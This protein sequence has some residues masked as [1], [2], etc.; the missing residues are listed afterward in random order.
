MKRQIFIHLGDATLSGDM[1]EDV[2]WVVKEPDNALSPLFHGDLKTASN[3]AYGCRVVVF[4]S[5]VEVLLTQVELPN[6]NRQKLLKAIPFALEEQLA[7]DVD[8]LHFAVGERDKVDQISC[9]IVERNIIEKWLQG[10]NDA[11]I[12]P[13]VVSTEVFGVPYEENVW[14]L[15]VKRASKESGA[16]AILRNNPQA[17]MALDVANVVPLLRASLESLAEE[18]RPKKLHVVLCDESR[19]IDPA[20][21]EDVTVKASSIAVVDEAVGEDARGSS[22]APQ[23]NRK[24]ISDIEREHDELTTAISQLESLCPPMG[25]DVAIDHNDQSYLIYIAQQFND[26]QCLNLLQGDYSR[27]ERLEKLFRPWRPA[28]AIGL[29][30]IVL[31]AGLVFADYQQLSK[32]DQML[33]T[34]IEQIYRDAFPDSKNIVDPK[35]QMERGLAQLRE[36]TNQSTD[37]FIL[38]S[39]A[40]DVLSD[41][42]TLKIRT[43]RY[44]AETLDLDFEISDLQALDEFKLR[45]LNEADLI[46]DIQSA[47]SREGKVESRMRISADAKLDASGKTNAKPDAKK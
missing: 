3:H 15:L 10:L 46:V 8:D 21:A 32:K 13:D 28:V 20:L 23:K 31:Q 1:P 29:T 11:G 5:G 25:I 38:L 37:M 42:E 47:S 2:H 9:A 18:L 14:T 45:L 27:R 26:T 6:M 39:K 44:K 19:S 35:L 24:S 43:L 34:Q 22:D 7:S 12:Q 40:G 16:K 33:R 17:G 30:W 41:T 36:Q 4:V